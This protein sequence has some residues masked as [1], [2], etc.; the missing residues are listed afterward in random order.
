MITFAGALAGL[1]LVWVALSVALTVSLLARV[2]RRAAELGL[3]MPRIDPVQALLFVVAPWSALTHHAMDREPEMLDGV[4]E[5][6]CAP[7]EPPPPPPWR[8]GPGVGG[9]P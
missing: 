2:N 5:L 7:L 9:A 3:V 6:V 8:D 1:A 4:L